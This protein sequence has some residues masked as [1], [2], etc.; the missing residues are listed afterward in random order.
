MPPAMFERA[1][2]TLDRFAPWHGMAPVGRPRN[3]L[4][5]VPPDET[6]SDKNPAV[7]AIEFVEV[8]RPLSRA[9]GERRFGSRTDQPYALSVDRG[10]R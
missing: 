4:D 9:P 2:Q 1:G 8:A 5:A 3:Y 10:R 7:E 6:S